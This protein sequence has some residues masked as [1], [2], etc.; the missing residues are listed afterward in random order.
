MGA[1]GVS[2]S[3]RD[4]DALRASI[5]LDRAHLFSFVLFFFLEIKKIKK[6]NCVFVG[7]TGSFVKWRNRQ[8]HCTCVGILLIV[9][10]IT[11]VDEITFMQQQLFFLR[12]LPE[13]PR[14]LAA[15]IIN[16]QSATAATMVLVG[17]RQNKDYQPA[18][19]ARDTRQRL[20]VSAIKHVAATAVAAV[21]SELFAAGRQ[22]GRVLVT[23]WPLPW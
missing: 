21:S 15:V 22:A 3:Q 8:L 12:F 1:D 23:L 4:L 10:T 14:L 2:G 17:K 16:R 13:C 6:V 19:M 9:V 18:A 5:Y 20:L 11:C 7:F